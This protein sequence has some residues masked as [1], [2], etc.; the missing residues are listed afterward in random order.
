MAENENVSMILRFD[1]KVPDDL[2]HVDAA[3]AGMLTVGSKLFPTGKV[4]IS[5]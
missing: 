4:G 1:N 2:N 3:V 5:Q